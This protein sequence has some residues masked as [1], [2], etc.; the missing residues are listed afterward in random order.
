MSM[1]ENETNH[2]KVWGTYGDATNYED[3]FTKG[4]GA[5][6]QRDTFVYEGDKTIHVDKSTYDRAAVGHR[7]WSGNDDDAHDQGERSTNDR[8]SSS[9]LKLH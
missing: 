9:P 1:I 5:I 8:N 2:G 7:E 6:S 4:K 3:S